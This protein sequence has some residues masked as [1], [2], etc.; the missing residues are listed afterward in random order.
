MEKFNRQNHW[1][2]IYQTKQLNEVSWYQPIPVTSLNFLKQLPI[3]TTANIIDIGGG[4]GLLVDHL[5][6][7]GY[8]NITVLDIS[9]TAINRAKVR[10]GVLTNKVK[11]IIADVATF[12]P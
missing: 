6:N 4:D 9:E 10:L 3:S 1:E 11:W 8:H 5:L 7:L 2:N 12:K